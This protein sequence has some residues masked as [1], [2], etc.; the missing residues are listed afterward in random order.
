MASGT[1]IRFSPLANRSL[2]IFKGTPRKETSEM[3]L[4]EQQM[5]M[6]M[7]LLDKMFDEDNSTALQFSE[8][9][10]T[11]ELVTLWEIKSEL[12]TDH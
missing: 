9:F 7:T 5:A 11:D 1:P 12:V 4:T 3:N 2:K 6:I 8:M 10:G